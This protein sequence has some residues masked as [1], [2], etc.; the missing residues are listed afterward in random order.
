MRTPGQESI[1]AVHIREDAGETAERAG[2]RPEVLARIFVNA[3]INLRSTRGSKMKRLTGTPGNDW[4][5][6]IESHRCIASLVRDRSERLHVFIHQ[7]D[8]RADVYETEAFDKRLRR[9]WSSLDGR[10]SS[11]DVSILES[12]YIEADPQAASSESLPR[13]TLHH[14]LKPRQ[15]QFSDLVLP[16][17]AGTRQKKS[18]LVIG[19]GPPGSGKTVV[20][21]DL[22]L[23]AV[24]D[25]LKVDVLVPSAPLKSDYRR[26]FEACGLRVS[27]STEDDAE[28]RLLEFPEHF[29]MLANESI[30]HLRERHIREWWNTQANDPKFRARLGPKVA[31]EV[32]GRLPLLVDAVLA[33]Q[34]FWDGWRERRTTKDFLGQQVGECIEALERLR[35][36]LEPC[37]ATGEPLPTRA[38]LAV[39]ALERSRAIEPPPHD[40]LILV[41]EAQDLAPAECRALLAFWL[42]TRDDDPHAIRELVFLG[43]QEQRISLVP[44][45]W[46]E[47]KRT[48]TRLTNLKPD[49]IREEY[50]DNASYR[51]RQSIARVA[52]A[53][54][55]ERIMGKAKSR[56][57][58]KLDVESL[59][60]GGTIDVLITHKKIDL[61]THAKQAVSDASPGDHLFIV[62][63][64]DRQGSGDDSHIFSYNVRQ[65][66]GLE[67]SK[68]IVDCPFG[69]QSGRRVRDPL[70]PDAVME[71][72]VA[73]SR[74][75]EHLLLVLDPASWA[76]L[77]RCPE[78][79]Q[80]DGV[81]IHERPIDSQADPRNLLKD[82][83]VT[84][85]R[86]ELQKTLLDQLTTRC[87]AA[88]GT[89]DSGPDGLVRIIRR[90]CEQ[91]DPDMI[92]S[93]LVGSKQ[94]AR[95]HVETLRS[96]W[97]KGL[98]AHRAGETRIAIGILLL[99]GEAGAAF[100]IATTDPGGSGYGWDPELLEVSAYESTVQSLRRMQSLEEVLSSSSSGFIQRQTRELAIARIRRGMDR[101]REAVAP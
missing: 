6:R 37:T 40:R 93:F 72:Y 90:L 95:N 86:D 56:Q 41:D 2:F 4:R 100:R 8:K 36:Q 1:P 74:A 20:A 46:D 47:L 15:Q 55:D 96:L 9:F 43:D 70:P 5:L 69:H 81:R 32:Q 44:F 33:D 53:V 57:Q 3:W 65:A 35:D 10:S 31:G 27:Q 7:F 30:D 58:T 29:A 48:A 19:R 59:E 45:S 52:R 34:E 63:G 97:V 14:E 84:L 51:M 91:P 87:E 68:V 60:G 67:A 61:W 79:W 12:E 94:L 83:L 13:G 39:T 98:A 77:K 49:Q 22:V 25:G 62:G 17:R 85:S 73:A 38:R 82:C 24:H 92:E 88:D 26:L 76:E 28:V 101:I 54:W 71:F 99:A 11:V 42:K 64:P 75:R 50:V 23:E 21:Q 78:P 80:L 18:Q 16:I 66:K 89:T